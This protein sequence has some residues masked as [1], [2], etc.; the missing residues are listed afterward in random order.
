MGGP[1]DDTESY[2]HDTSGPSDRAFLELLDG[3]G[4]N[5]SNPEAFPILLPSTLGLEWC[6]E[7]G[8]QSLAVK[9]ARLRYAQA[10]YS[11]HQIRQVLGLKS[12]LFRTQVRSADAKKAKTRAWTTIHNIDATAK[13]HARIYSMSR[14]AYQ[15]IQPIYTAGLELPQLLPQ[16][17]HVETLVLGSEQVG[18]RNTQQ[19]WIW[20]FGKTVDDDGTWMNDCKLAISCLMFVCSHMKQLTG[21]T[22]YVLRHN[23]RGGWK[24]RTAYTTR[25]IGFLLFFIPRQRC[26]RIV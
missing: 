23:S 12:S 20:G 14:D 2:D 3:S 10:N 11:I 6:V 9:E 15:R 26:G 1:P 18:Q 5:T 24:N 19:S 16:D 4:M 25:L 7:H 13:E 21:C 17:L 22:G 8:I